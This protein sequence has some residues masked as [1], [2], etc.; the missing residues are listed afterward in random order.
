MRN[1]AASLS[2][3]LQPLGIR[4]NVVAP[5][6]IDTPLT[7]AL[8]ADLAERRGVAVDMIEAERAAVIPMGRAGTSEE[9]ADSCL[10]LLSDRSSYL[11]GSTMFATGGVLAGMI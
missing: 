2:L 8:N 9:V 10:Y 4:V 3:L 5:G 1:L 11:T 7:A 6:L